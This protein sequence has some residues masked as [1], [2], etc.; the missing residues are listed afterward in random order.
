MRYRRK[1]GAMRRVSSILCEH[2]GEARTR[3]YLYIRGF[4]HGNVQFNETHRRGQFKKG[5]AGST[6]LGGSFPYGGTFPVFVRSPL[7]II[8]PRCYRL[9]EGSFQQWA[10]L[11][12]ERATSAPVIC[13]S[14]NRISGEM[15]LL[16]CPLQRNEGRPLPWRCHLQRDAIVN[17][18]L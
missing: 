10:S 3:A 12:G 14:V 5:E 13:Y 1:T 17:T 4:S 15:D 9:G 8:N 7:L 6:R 2:Q 11:P 18:Q 16:A